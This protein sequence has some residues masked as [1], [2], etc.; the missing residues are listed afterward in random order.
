MSGVTSEVAKSLSGR[1]LLDVLVPGWIDRD[2]NIPE[3]RPQPIVL[4]LRLDRGLVR[5]TSESQY[6]HLT[7]RQE[8]LAEWS[9]I[10]LLMRAEDEIALASC[11]EQLFGD[12][13]GELACVTVRGY[14]T[15]GGTTSTLAIDFD[16]GNT[17]FLDPSWTFGIRMGHGADEANWLEKFANGHTRHT[18]HATAS[19]D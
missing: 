14:E 16:G 11:A 2:S 3:F 6:D 13:W 5:L 18:V 12:G 17:L 9:D 1:R 15:M 8:D 10:E 19:A 7:A 4:W